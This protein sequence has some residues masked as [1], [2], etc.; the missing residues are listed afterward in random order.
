[1]ADVRGTAALVSVVIPVLNEAE[2]VAP[3]TAAL[4]QTF[5]SLDRR[6]EILF[7]DD[8]SS[9]KTSAV[10]SNLHEGNPNIK[11]CSLHRSFGHQAALSA[12]LQLASGDAVIV[13]DGD[14]QHPVS[15]LP[16]MISHWINGAQVVNTV[17][18]S[19]GDATMIK[20]TLSRLFYRVF[21]FLSGIELAS[22]SADFRLLD[23]EVVTVLNNL[24]ERRRF[25]RG[26]VAWLGYDSVTVEYRAATRQSGSSKFGVGKMLALALDGITSFSSAPLILS[27]ALGIGISFLGF[28]YLIYVIYVSLVLQIAVTGWA[29]ILCVILIIGGIQLVVLGI[30]GV[31]IARI[32]DEAKRRPQFIIKRTLG[33]EGKR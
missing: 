8:G 1:M 33:L 17:R 20:T 18:Q 10:V 27:L 25:L 31:Y 14:G 29:S 12:G 9:D 3:L 11:L 23:R 19:E 13:M 26:L 4:V 5:G 15:L 21:S 32:F 22:G 24:P 6:Y 16:E 28:L 7:V 2:S 30:L